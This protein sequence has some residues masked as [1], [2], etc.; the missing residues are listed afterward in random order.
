MKKNSLLVI[1]IIL[2][3]IIFLCLNTLHAEKNLPKMITIGTMPV[4]TT[5]NMAGCGIAVVVN[6]HTP[7]NVK[8]MPVANESV[9]IPMLQSG[10]VQL[11]VG[12]VPEVEKAYL[13]EGLWTKYAKQMKIKGFPARMVALGAKAY[14]GF[15]VRG[16]SP[17][18]NIGDLKGAKIARFAP[19][20][21][22]YDQEVA[23]LASA[24][25]SPEDVT[26]IPIANPVESGKALMDGRVDASWV[27]PDAPVIMELVSKVNARYLPYEIS[28]EAQE[29]IK[30]VNHSLRVE[31]PEMVI[32]HV[33][34]K[35]KPMLVFDWALFTSPEVSNDVIYE[36]TKAVYENAKE[37]NEKPALERWH[38]DRFCS[39]EIYIPYHDGSIKFYKEIGLWN[40]QMDKVQ[41]SLLKKIQ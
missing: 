6:N 34:D 7:I 30:K 19:G 38:A 22:L 36:I 37:L 33:M 26:F 39:N 25:L 24:E 2:P 32:P 5:V 14:L 16:D 1:S 11:G 3:S 27:A 9:W 21:A 28:P 40:D 4:G 17:Y 20:T 10:E 15:N 29:R 23:S 41:S 8:V 35:E 13:G 18:K 12:I 31:Y